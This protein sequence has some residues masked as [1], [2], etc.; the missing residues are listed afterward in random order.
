MSIVDVVGDFLR[1]FLVQQLGI[2]DVGSDRGRQQPMDDHIGVPADRRCEM[3]VN[4]TSQ[5]VVN[6]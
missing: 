2:R 4:R 3:G 6:E 1:L 5:T